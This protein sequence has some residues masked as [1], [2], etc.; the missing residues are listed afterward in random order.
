MVG[1]RVRV[2]RGVRVGGGVS[3]GARRATLVGA[4]EKRLT[5]VGARVARVGESD[6]AAPPQPTKIA[7]ITIKNI[8]KPRDG[9]KT[10]TSLFKFE[11]YRDFHCPNRTGLTILYHIHPFRSIAEKSDVFRVK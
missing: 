3:V 9:S 6:L 1:T 7:L 10:C 4:D 8:K 5:R 11:E 2:G